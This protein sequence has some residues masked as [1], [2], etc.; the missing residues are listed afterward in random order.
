MFFVVSSRRRHTR[1]AL[2]TGVQTCALP[3]YPFDREVCLAEDSEAATSSGQNSAV[4]GISVID[5]KQL[6]R[7]EPVHRGF[8]YHHLYG[9]ICLLLAGAAGADRIVVEADEDI[10]IVLPDGRRYVQVKKRNGNLASG[11]IS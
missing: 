9:V 1:C 6:I 10:E 8:L 2:V 7:I 11:D 3:I 5:E 4:D